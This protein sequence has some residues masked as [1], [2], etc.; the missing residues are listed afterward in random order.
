MK[1][2]AA[3]PITARLH[4][5]VSRLSREGGY[6]VA[7]ADVA[8]GVARIVLLERAIAD[9][10]DHIDHVPYLDAAGSRLSDATPAVSVARAVLGK[11]ASSG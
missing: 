6:V 2:G 1:D 10:L 5:L 4:A 8:E 7:Q 3:Q 9:L 11:R